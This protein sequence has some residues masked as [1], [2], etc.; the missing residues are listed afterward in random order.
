MLLGTCIAFTFIMLSLLSDGGNSAVH[1]D[2]MASSATINNRIGGN[3]KNDFIEAK[4]IRNTGNI[5]FASAVAQTLF[6]IDSIRNFVLTSNDKGIAPLKRLFEGLADHRIKV[7]TDHDGLFVPGPKGEQGD[8]DEFFTTWIE[9]LE[10]VMNIEDLHA[11]LF[12]KVS[13][14]RT[15]TKLNSYS[16]FTELWPAI[17]INFPHGLNT[18]LSL[19]LDDLLGDSNGPFGEEKLDNYLIQ[20][21]SIVTFPHYIALIFGRSTFDPQ[22][23]TVKIKTAVNI[24]GYLD[25]SKYTITKTSHPR[26]IYRL[27]MFIIHHGHPHSGHYLVYVRD[28]GNVWKMINDERVVD[29]SG[30]EAFQVVKMASICFYERN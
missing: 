1:L 10:G 26:P 28:S 2:R 22:K 27:K 13:I 14:N 8:S 23:G 3:G 17:R 30:K 11:D 5:C 18:T 9:K 24:P 16:F 19:G 21:Q 6:R 4:G 15:N 12:L 7:V 25:L 20:K 29:V